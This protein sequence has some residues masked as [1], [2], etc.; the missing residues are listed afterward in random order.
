M[1]DEQFPVRLQDIDIMGTDSDK[2]ALF[3]V[4]RFCGIEMLAVQADLSI[5]ISI[6]VLIP[7]YIEVFCR[8]REKVL[9][10]LLKE[11]G[12]LSPFFIMRL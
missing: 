1:T 4:F 2:D 10:V 3:M 9:T 8:K 7:T 5:T 12:Y 11:L 6:A